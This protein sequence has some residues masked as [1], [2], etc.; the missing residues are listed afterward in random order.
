MSSRNQKAQAL[1]KQEQARQPFQVIENDSQSQAAYQQ[2]QAQQQQQSSGK[3]MKVVK[4]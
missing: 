4:E 3:G 2:F 1:K